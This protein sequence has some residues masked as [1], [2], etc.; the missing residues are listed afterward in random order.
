MPDSDD[1]TMAAGSGMPHTQATSLPLKTP[2]NSYD[3]PPREAW[4][5]SFYPY[6]AYFT[7]SVRMIN[8]T[9]ESTPSGAPEN[10]RYESAA[11]FTA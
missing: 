3:K 6:F 8:F 7:A 11:S 2:P 9:L 10:V 5:R 4:R 1:G